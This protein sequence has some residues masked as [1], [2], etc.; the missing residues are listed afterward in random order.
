MFKS[1][2]VI[3]QESKTIPG[4]EPIPRIELTCEREIQNCSTTFGDPRQ[5]DKID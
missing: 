1:V 5:T 3:G 2:R 4:R